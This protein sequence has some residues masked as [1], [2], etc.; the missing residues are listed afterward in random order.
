MERMNGEVAAPDAGSGRGY[1]RSQAQRAVLLVA[2]LT[3]LVAL[4]LLTWVIVYDPAHR[5]SLFND[6]YP[7][8]FTDLLDRYISP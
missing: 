2:A 1:Q 8:P 6:R 5:P 7:A 4:C 3:G